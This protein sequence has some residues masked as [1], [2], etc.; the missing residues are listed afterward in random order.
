MVKIAAAGTTFQMGSDYTETGR[1]SDE[2]PAHAVTFTTDYYIGKYELTQGQ[3]KAIMNGSN[4]S[5]FK[6]GDDLPVENISWNDLNNAGG[7][8]E[9]INALKPAGYSGFR[10]PTE[11]EWEYAARGGTQTRFYWGDDLSFENA[12]DYSWNAKNSDSTTHPVGQKSPNKFGLY[13]MS[14]NVWE[15]CG[16]WYAGYGGTP[17]TDPAGPKTGLNRV[18]R[19]GSWSHDASFCRS[20]LRFIGYPSSRFRST[21]FRLALPAGGE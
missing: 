4:P 20:A 10:L 13:D 14:G 5:Y 15:L 16:D 18:L 8:L 7:F 3:W 1:Y 21:G 19:G 11:A 17:A 6:S 12:G 2:G 9:K